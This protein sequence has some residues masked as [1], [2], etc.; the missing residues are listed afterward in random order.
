[1]TGRGQRGLLD[2][3]RDVRQA[4]GRALTGRQSERVAHRGPR[5][6][7]RTTTVRTRV[8]YAPVR[9]RRA[10]PGE[11]VWAWVPFDDDASQGKDRPLLVIGRVGRDVAALQLTSR[12][13]DDRHHHPIGIGTW[14]RDLRPSWVKLDRVLRIAPRRI[15]REG[16]ALDRPRFDGVVAAWEAYDG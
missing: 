15:R 3:L 2:L 8:A 9:D 12:A 11:I 4:M 5:G 6:A 1:M 13:H 10:D 16:G 7:A 14:D